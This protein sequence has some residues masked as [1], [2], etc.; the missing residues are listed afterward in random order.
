MGSSEDPSL[1]NNV[2]EL[3][4]VYEGL[5]KNQNN[6]GSNTTSLTNG[7]VMRIFFHTDTHSPIYR[8]LYLHTDTLSPIYK[9]L[10]LHTDTPRFAQF[11]VRQF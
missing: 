10:Y 5:N 9:Y 6:F 2:D 3:G 4:L 8:Y 11:Q 7:M 1:V